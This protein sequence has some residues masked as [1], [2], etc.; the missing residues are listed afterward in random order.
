MPARPGEPIDWKPPDSLKTAS[1]LIGAAVAD[2]LAPAPPSTRR[3][4]MTMTADAFLA[5]NRTSVE[6]SLTQESR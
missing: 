4:R 6:V 5:A 2:A 3:A 1:I